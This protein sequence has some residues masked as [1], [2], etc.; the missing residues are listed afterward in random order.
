MFEDFLQH[1]FIC[2]PHYIDGL[3]QDCSNLIAN[4]ME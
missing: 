2:E 4:A 1:L 3:T